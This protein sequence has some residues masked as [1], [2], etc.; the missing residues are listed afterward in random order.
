MNAWQL[1]Y[2][3]ISQ[4]WLVQFKAIRSI[5]DWTVMLYLIIPGLFFAIRGYYSLWAEGL[6][7]WIVHTPLAVLLAIT[8][9]LVRRGGIRMLTEPGDALFLQQKRDWMRKLHLLGCFYSIS[10]ICV[11]VVFFWIVLLPVFIRVHHWTIAQWGIMLFFLCMKAILQALIQNLIQTAWIGW[12]RIWRTTLWST[13]VALIYT[14]TMLLGHQRLWVFVAVGVLLLGINVLLIQKRV[15]RF[16]SFEGDVEE[17]GRLKIKLT[18]LLLRDAV[19]PPIKSRLRRAIIFR[20]SN[21]L[22]H[23]RSTHLVLAESCIKSMY[24]SGSQFKTLGMFIGAATL[25]I[26]LSPVFVRY[27]LGFGLLLLV[28]VWLTGLWREFQKI[29]YL[30]NFP[31][32]DE[33]RY[34]A[35]SVAVF[36]ML[37]PIALWFCLCIGLL[38]YGWIGALIALPIGIVGSWIFSR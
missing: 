10:L 32:A 6:P 30:T 23:N 17:E 13:I 21:R 22:F 11:M 12:R 1:G 35:R 19:D 18:A 27:I 28:R 36:G 9:F 26:L 4:Q 33:E 3:R 34:R 2:R 38:S 25:A 5:A 14:M 20:K 37:F 29:P 15:N 16:H 31:W 8:F 24:R 7:G